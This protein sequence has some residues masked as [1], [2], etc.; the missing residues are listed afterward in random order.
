M[1]FRNL[2]ENF[3][4]KKVG[5]IGDLML[6]RYL[7][8]DVNRIS[9]EAPVPVARVIDEKYVLGGAANVAANVASLGGRAIIFGIIGADPRGELLKNFFKE[10]GIDFSFTFSAMNRPTTVKTRLISGGQQIVRVDRE[11][12][13]EINS[14]EENIFLETLPKFLD[15]VDIVIISDYDKG[16]VTENIAKKVIEFGEEKKMKVLADPVPHTFHKYINAFMIKPNKKEAEEISG[17]KLKKGLSNISEFMQNLH[18]K[19]NSNLVV[20]L[21]QD[22]VAISEGENIFVLP[23]YA[24]EVFDV[25]GAGDTVM[26]ALALSLASGADLK[27]AALVGNYSAGIVVGK[28]GTATVTREELL[29]LISDE[30]KNK[31]EEIL[32]KASRAA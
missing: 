24:R 27:T 22:G 3:S 2:I 4:E 17:I 20:T 31:V 23:T 8:C 9:P 1:D 16:L 19:L 12:T 32:K 21:G 25:S 14:D 18:E 26:A 15:A 29:K 13:E 7:F 11:M 28:T 10:K 6:D 5:I 30:G